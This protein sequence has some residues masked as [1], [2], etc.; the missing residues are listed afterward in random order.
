MS[1][2]MAIILTRLILTNEINVNAEKDLHNGE[3]DG[4]TVDARQTLH[5]LRQLNQHLVILAH[6]EHELTT[7]TTTATLTQY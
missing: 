2:I 7:I 5:L 3:A 6:V 4:F 1:Q